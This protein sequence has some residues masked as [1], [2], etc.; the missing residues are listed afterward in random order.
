MHHII[1]GCL[2]VVVL[3]DGPGAI[4]THES[5]LSLLL[6]AYASIGKGG[7]GRS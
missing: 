1:C 4:K 3:V 7:P 5:T 6:H 2:V